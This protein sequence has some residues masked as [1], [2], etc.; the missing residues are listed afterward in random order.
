MSENAYRKGRPVWVVDAARTP[1]LKAR[2]KPGPFAA[3]DLAFWAGRALLERQPFAPEAL[4]EVVL[5]CVM[6]SPNEV[7]IARVVALRLGLGHKVPAF[8]V[9]RNCA[10]GMQALDTA[11]RDIAVGEAD[12][13]L[14]G[15][16]EAMSR[17]PLLFD[18]AMVAWLGG[19]AAAKSLPAKARH[20]AAFRPAMLTPVIGLLRGLTDPV[21]GLSMGQ[22]AEIVAHR[23]GI[24]RAAMDAF[25]L[26]SHQRAAAA[27]CAGRLQGIEI[28]YDADGN[29]HDRDDG[30]RPDSSL[31]KLAELKP[32]FDRPVGR[33]TAG[34]SAQ[35]TDGASLLLLASDAAVARHQLP[36]LG[37]LVDCA[38]AGLDPAQMGLGPVHAIAR[39]LGRTGLSLGDIDYFEINEAFAA[40]VLGCCAALA[41]AEYCRQ[42]LGLAAPLG[43]IPPERLNADGGAVALGHPVGAS[44]ARVVQQLLYTLKGRG[45][46]RGIAS[47]CIGGGQGGAMVVELA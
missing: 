27:Q 2:G 9:Q 21:I 7:N 19:L 44:G 17:A 32:V 43:Q 11:A 34:N 26:A 29:Y 39:V 37:R 47:L 4:D 8:T 41:D 25:A 31:E 35:I 45:A 1:H 22:T 46:R 38:W 20:L 42:E 10:S 30:V 6:P 18:L 5:G 14:A 28:L 36:V 33:V 12:L 3:A 13:V 15:G 24:D 40:Q 23:F 16:V